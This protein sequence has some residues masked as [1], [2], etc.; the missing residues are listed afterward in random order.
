MTYVKVGLLFTFWSLVGVLFWVLAFSAVSYLYR[1]ITWFLRRR[2]TFKGAVI[3][4][5]VYPGYILMVMVCAFIFGL[6]F[7]DWARRMIAGNVDEVGGLIG[8]IIALWSWIVQPGEIIDEEYLDAVS[9]FLKN[10]NSQGL[11]DV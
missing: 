1:S 6:I 11:T 3:S 5:C 8:F 9:R 4:S 2:I 10:E 7:P